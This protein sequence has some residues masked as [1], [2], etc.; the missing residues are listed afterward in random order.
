MSIV[1]TPQSVSPGTLTLEQLDGLAIEYVRIQWTDIANTTRCRVVAIAHFKKLLKTERPGVTMVSGTP[2]A[3]VNFLPPGHYPVGEQLLAMDL[4]TLR[5][6]PFAPGQAV[7]HGFFQERV[8]VKVDGSLSIEVPYCP[9]TVLSNITKKA[10]EKLGVEFL[11]GF[12]SEFTLLESTKPVKAVSDGAWSYASSFNAGTAGQKVLD[13]IAKQIRASGI[14]LLI[15]HSEGGPGQYEVVT[16]P[17]PPLEAAD[18]LIQTRQIIYNAASKH[19]LRATFAPR[20]YS[21]NCGTACHAHLSVHKP[22]ATQPISSTSPHLNA[23]ESSFLAGLL[24]HLPAVTAFTLPQPA[25]YS[26]VVD[27]IWSGGTWV[28]WGIDNK[29]VPV[30]LCNYAFPASRNFEVKCIDG[31]ANPYLALSAVLGAGLTG[32]NKGADLHVRDCSVDRAP[33]QL[34]EKERA[35]LGIVDRMALSW[36]DAI[37]KLEADDELIDAIGRKSVDAYLA[38]NKFLS[39]FM[40]AGSEEDVTTRL[41]E[42]Y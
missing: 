3:I 2:L 15:Y 31:L 32:V 7:V 14:E 27:G 33:G 41:V 37:A 19:E 4:S 35:E 34:N 10:E 1:Y 39:S 40:V 26:R 8:P 38:V 5:P 36:E 16:G 29:E 25:S 28:S 6:L 9:R 22:G 23:L 20:V 17:L 42:S 12:E 24:N 18:A 21:D 13:E 11:V 30:R